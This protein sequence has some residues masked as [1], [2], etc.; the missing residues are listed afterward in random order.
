LPLTGV[1]VTVASVALQGS[2]TATT[3][4]NGVFSLPGLA[5]GDYTVRFE[6]HNMASVQRR[7]TVALGTTIVLDQELALGTRQRDGRCAG[8]ASVGGHRAR[9]G[10]SPAERDAAP[11]GRKNA[12]SD[13]GTVAGPDRTTPQASR[14]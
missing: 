1:T 13:R 4:V 14:R 2:R 8:V 6:L 12:V 7:A 11:A 10:Q 3:D 5:P 9:F